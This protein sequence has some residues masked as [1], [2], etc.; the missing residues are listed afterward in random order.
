LVYTFLFVGITFSSCK[1]ND[2]TRARITVKDAAGK[3]ITGA[4]VDVYCDSGKPCTVKDSQTTDSN[5]QSMHTFDLPAVLK[6]KAV[7]TESGTTMVGEGFVKLEE[8]E[9]VEKTITVY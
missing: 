2:P 9:T 8:H 1:N 3:L 7:K 4:K 5:G 6:V